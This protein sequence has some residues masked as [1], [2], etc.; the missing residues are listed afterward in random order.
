M[1]RV[2]CL[3]AD[4]TNMPSSSSADEHPSGE[5]ST[6]ASSSASPSA[7]SSVSSRASSSD[8]SS[9]DAPQGGAS[10]DDAVIDDTTDI[11]SETLRRF[12]IGTEWHTGTDAPIET[13]NPGNGRPLARVARASLR[14]VEAAV[15]CADRNWHD[16]PWRRLQPDARAAV[17]RR[18]GDRLLA[19][20]D[21]LATLLMRDSGEPIARCP[22]A[23]TDAA[24]CFHY[25][26]A[27]C[28]T[29]QDELTSPRG[30]EVTMALA[31]PRGVVTAITPAAAPLL[32][33]VRIVAP[34][35]AAGNAVILK[36][37]EQSP[38]LALELARIASSAGLPDGLLTVLP[39]D[40]EE[41]GAA[42][43]KHP[44]VRMVSFNGPT[45]IG[46]DVATTAGNRLIPVALALSG[47]A[48]HIVFDDAD[49]DDALDAVCA[50][51]FESS[52]QSSIAGSRLF[53]H[54]PVYGRFVD[55]L[56]HRA[57][58]L[59]VGLPDDPQTE[60]GPL[61]SLARLE[62]VRRHVDFARS[63]GG[64][65]LTGGKSPPEPELADGWFYQPT[66]IEGLGSSSRTCREEVVGPVLNC[67]PFKD[68]A[69]LIRQVND[70]IHGIAASVWSAD[71]VRAWR[72]AREVNAGSVWINAAG[73]PQWP[74][75]FGD[76][77]SGVAGGE[78]GLHGLRRYTRIKSLYLG[79]HPGGGHLAG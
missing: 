55:A 14:D 34:A 62:R 54:R 68:E 70:T 33:A 52:G 78:H 31:E 45:L 59:R 77:R 38:L 28:E 36:P 40:G 4:L 17:L 64:R 73:P 48:P 35:L 41:I 5:S 69:D 63:E 42:L 46:R 74:T 43:V 47:N 75:A 7:T 8:R 6:G 57:R 49:I 32:A 21:A 16:A 39:G 3:P 11:D 51:V 67:L 76:G 9:R 18:I 10:A 27:L 79:L 60:V 30:P 12:R 53:L 29:W 71:T 24:A 44:D 26:A 13:L 19:E 58:S 23:V 56:V 2:H 25:Y 66:V 15:A 65:V 37:S 22:N 50:A 61:A 72:I 1:A 20:R